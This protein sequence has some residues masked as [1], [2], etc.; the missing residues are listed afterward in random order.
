MPALSLKALQG[1]REKF[2]DVCRVTPGGQE[3]APLKKI[4]MVGAVMD[5]KE[6]LGVYDRDY[7]EVV[8]E[9]LRVRGVPVAADFEI[10][11]CNLDPQYGGGDFLRDEGIEA[12][13]VIACYIFDPRTARRADDPEE[14]RD[15]V[16]KVSEQHTEKGVWHKSARRAGV[17][18]IAVMSATEDSEEIQADSFNGSGYN[19]DQDIEVELPS[20]EPG[21]FYK[22]EILMDEAFQRSLPQSVPGH[23][24]R[25]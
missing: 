16:F 24:P 12:D 19:I 15:L 14:G 6:A 2:A 10:K 13:I 7:L 20:A 8:M 22:L 25:P 3:C 9:T 11:I 5:D 21:S 4:L 23:S 17:K 18:V 1:L